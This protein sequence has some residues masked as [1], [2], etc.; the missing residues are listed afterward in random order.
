MMKVYIILQS[1]T[2]RLHPLQVQYS[3]ILFLSNKAHPPWLQLPLQPQ[4]QQPLLRVFML[5]HP[6]RDICHQNL[7]MLF[8]TTFRHS[9]QLFY[10]VFS[11]GGRLLSTQLKLLCTRRYALAFDT[12]EQCLTSS[13]GLCMGGDHGRIL[14]IAGL[15]LSHSTNT[16]LKQRAIQHILYDLLPAG[17]YL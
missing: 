2:R 5:Y 4:A 3:Q 15:R 11:L 14:G 16:T 7:V 10:F 9:R 8:V 1:D 13:T 6:R 12:W 17:S